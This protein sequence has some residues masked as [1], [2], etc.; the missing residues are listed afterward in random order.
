[1]RVLWQDLQYA[2]RLFRKKPGFTLIAILTLGLGIGANTAVFSVVNAFLLRPLPYKDPDRLVVVQ[3]TAASA[4]YDAVDSYPVFGDVRDQ[5]ESL[6]EV[7]AFSWRRLTL[8]GADGPEIVFGSSVTANFFS[9]VGATPLLGRAFLSGEDEPGKPPLVILSHGLWQRRFG[10]DPN[11]VGRTFTSDKETVEIVG[12]MPPDFKFDLLPEIPRVEF[13]MPMNANPRMRA[14][15]NI[16]WLRIIARLA[17][18]A[19]LAQTRAELGVIAERIRED[20][21]KPSASSPVRLREDFSLSAIPVK[22]FFVGEAQKPL[23]TLLGAVGFVLLIAC[24]NVANLLLAHGV[25]RQ[26]EIAIRAVLGA[27]RRRLISQMLTESLLLSLAGGLLGLLFVTWLLE[28]VVW[29]TPKYLVRMEEITLDGRVF[30]FTLLASLCTGVV[31]G[32]L[33][34]LQASKVD[35]Q[36]TLKSG[37]AAGG[38][39]LRGFRNL[40]VVAEVALAVIL[41]VGAGLMV[42]SFIR[43]TNVP[44]GFDPENVLSLQLNMLARTKE[45]EQ[46]AFAREAVERLQSLPGVT[47]AALIDSLPVEG[48]S[49]VSNKRSKML[50]APL[51]GDADAE[52]K[53]EAHF[54]TPEYFQAMGIRL[55]SGRFFTDDDTAATPPVVVV[56]EW[57]AR[58]AWQGEDPIGKRLLWNWAEGQQPTVIGVVADVRQSN[59]SEEPS[60]I[61]YAPFDQSPQ[62]VVAAVVRTT[63]EP[64]SLTPAVREQILATDGRVAIGK[65]MTVEQKLSES[66]AQP[67]FYTVL[68]GWF[69]MAGML[70]ALIGLY[71]VISYSVSQMTHEVGIRIALGAQRRDILKLVVGHGFVLTITGIALGVGGAFALSR[72]LGSLLFGVTATDPVTYAVVCTLLLVTALLACY[73]PARRATRVDPMA[74]LRYE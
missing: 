74:A 44:V 29:L 20:A 12:V 73:L 32:L 65:V 67:R 55:V 47:S 37:A 4:E 71:G 54:A 7:A 39:A 27:N 58:Q 22:D 34:A 30:L 15:R 19:T 13:W 68:L 51:A 5:S 69:G 57:L 25:G 64:S 41:L 18:D 3:R 26:K 8:E 53:I 42:N 60:P 10:A 45:P 28:V 9:V 24:V 1:M 49:T 11:V 2:L 63:V 52:I 62:G 21:G 50:A 35:L 46:R 72:L 6:D 61:L 38:V 16:S 48:G 70:L 17:P 23:L 59:L 56:S 33:P 31:F 40:L 43:L 14:S 36:S 66:V